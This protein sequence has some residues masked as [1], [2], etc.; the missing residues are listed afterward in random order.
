MLQSRTECGMSSIGGS[1]NTS[2]RTKE[3]D[4]YAGSSDVKDDNEGM[5]GQN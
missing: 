2:M 5:V 4:E 1:P 3:G